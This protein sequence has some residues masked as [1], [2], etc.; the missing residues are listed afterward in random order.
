MAPKAGTRNGA[1]KAASSELPPRVA[2][3]KEKEKKE[4]GEKQKVSLSLP[5]N[6]NSFVKSR[7][8]V[9]HQRSDRPSVVPEIVM[10]I[11]GFDKSAFFVLA[12]HIFNCQTGL[13]VTVIGQCEKG[14]KI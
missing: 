11:L 3:E 7:K 5:L 13:W 12:F 6:G 9:I 8:E 4:Q 2:S 10:K 1:K 14:R